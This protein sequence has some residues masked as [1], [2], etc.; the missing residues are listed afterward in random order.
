MKNQSLAKFILQGE[1]PKPCQ[2]LTLSFPTSP[3]IFL[4]GVVGNFVTSPSDPKISSSQ[5]S[6]E[7]IAS[8]VM[9]V[10][11]GRLALVHPFSAIR[12]YFLETM[13]IVSILAIAK[14]SLVQGVSVPAPAE[15]GA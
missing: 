9:D 5:S 2:F 10:Y 3:R 14:L 15:K 6:S 12:T 13:L 8:I 7:P 4:L 11:T 1:K